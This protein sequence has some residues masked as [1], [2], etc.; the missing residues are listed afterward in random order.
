[1]HAGGDA[2]QLSEQLQATAFTVGADIFLGADAARP[3]TAAGDALLGHELGHVVQ[4]GG[5][6]QRSLRRSPS[7]APL[8]RPSTPTVQRMFGR[9][10]TSKIAQVNERVDQ[11]TRAKVVT[12]GELSNQVKTLESALGKLLK[13]HKTGNKESQSAAYGLKSAAERIL[14]NLPDQQSKASQVL[15][16]TYPEQVRRL[17]RIVDECQLIWDEHLV[18]MTKRKAGNIYNQEA[19]S[20][21]LSK[22]TGAAKHQGFAPLGDRPTEL[23][24]DYKLSPGQN[25]EQVLAGRQAGYDARKGRRDHGAALGLTPAET[26]AIITFTVEDYAY[27]NPATANNRAWMVAA[28]PAADLIDKP[29]KSPEEMDALGK[30]LTA[31]GVTARERLDERQQDLKARTEEGA[32]HAG[33]AMQ[34]LLKMPVW[35]GQLFRG[36]VLTEAVVK[37]RFAE[38][39][40]GKLKPIEKTI[41]RTTIS[42]ASK[43]EHVARGFWMVAWGKVPEPKVRVLYVM[44]T[45]NG[46]DIELLSPSSYEKE[47]ALLPGSEF[48]VVSAERDSNGAIIVKC[49]Q[50]R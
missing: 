28:N 14:G 5:G 8:G 2:A 42:S 6:V 47:V 29:H 39:R 26:A 45:T 31:S 41:K 18:E 16:R 27:I 37:E 36:E 3:G 30:S 13:A 12:V 33:M 48:S 21:G 23:P 35:R 24:A 17:Q 43:E 10:K 49:K 20:G 46:R 19:M 40:N 38:S 44:E 34:G 15:G 4:Q 22:L 1:M 32:L 50:R 11:S 7:L 9:K 25:A